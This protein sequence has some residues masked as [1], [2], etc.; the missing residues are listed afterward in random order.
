MH[1]HQHVEKRAAGRACALLSQ[2]QPQ[3]AAASRKA[4]RRAAGWRKGP[5]KR[6]SPGLIWSC[7]GEVSLFHPTTTHSPPKPVFMYIQEILRDRH[8]LDAQTH[9]PCPFSTTFSFLCQ[10]LGF[11]RKDNKKF[12]GMGCE[13]LSPS[14]CP[15]V[16]RALMRIATRKTKAK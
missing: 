9:Q 14:L 3:P 2:P 1:I 8:P 5:L 12:K 13:L 10:R 16:F 7:Y 4:P 15:Y 11:S 6:W